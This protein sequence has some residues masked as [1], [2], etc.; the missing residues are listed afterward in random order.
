VHKRIVCVLTALVLTFTLSESALAEENTTIFNSRAPIVSCKASSADIVTYAASFRGV[1][2][3]YGGTNPSGF[4]CSGFVQY[5][6]AHFGV[7]IPR[8]SQQQYSVGTAVSVSNL[9]PGDLVFFHDNGSGPGHVGLY[10][11]EGRMIHAPHTGDVVKI[12]PLEKG[13][14]GARR[15]R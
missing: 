8:T 5:V 2:Y 12:A 7:S 9:Q 6:Y 3:V 14:V 4:D 11:G 15:V 13:L 10:I 1:K